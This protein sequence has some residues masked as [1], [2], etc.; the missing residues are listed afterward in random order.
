MKLVKFTIPS[1][2]DIFIN[3]D[4]VAY[5]CQDPLGPEKTQIYMSN[6]DVY[7][8]KLSLEEIIKLLRQK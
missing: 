6:Q 2:R 1:G 8:I 4:Q 5:I 3:P 7:S